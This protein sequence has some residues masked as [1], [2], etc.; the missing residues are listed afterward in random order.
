ML[1]LLK[2][3]WLKVK[4]YKAFWIFSILYS[5]AILGINYTGYYINELALQSMP[6][7]QLLLGTPYA[8]PKV[9]QT[10]GWM[11]S[12][13]LYFPG[14][15]FIML[16]TNEFN[17]KT[18]RQ[19]IIDGW[20]RNQF[21][22]VKI[23]VAFLLSLISTLMVIVTAMIFGF[24]LDNPFSLEKFEYVGYYFIQAIIYTLASVLIAV[25]VRRGGLAIGFYFLY[26]VVLENALKAIMNR[27]LDDT[28]RFLPIQSADDL[29]PLPIFENIQ[30]Q[31]IKPPE[32]PI[33][34]STVAVYLV[35]Y[36]FF[37]N[38]KF[39]RSDL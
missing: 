12:W 9:W 36:L 11:S 38:R 31:I 27:Y 15:L 4:S 34:L 21:I 7:S 20:S 33:L 25:L 13:L 3:E 6:P 19:N 16:L 30:R 32:Y 28:G 18:H 29:I 37:I 26:V 5:F 8:F 39:L 17:F 10:V 24:Q 22:S 35:L 2:I 14:I 1:H 23:A